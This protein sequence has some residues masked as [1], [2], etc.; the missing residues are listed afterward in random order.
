MNF[1]RSV[2]IASIAVY[3][4]VGFAVFHT[5]QARH[6]EEE[7][8]HAY[9]SLHMAGDP[10]ALY[11]PTLGL[12]KKVEPGVYDFRTKSWNVSSKYP[13]FATLSARPNKIAGT[14]VIYAHNSAGLFKNITT[15]S[16]G[17]GVTIKVSDGRSFSY[18]FSHSELVSPTDISLFSEDS[19][20]R[21][22]LL[23]CEGKNDEFR[24]LVYFTLQDILKS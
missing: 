14:T 7:R 16:A 3:V 5:V 21:L 2:I 17:D 23:T 13:H 10:V 1:S 18:I 6:K 15:L 22:I 4:L 24:R 9:E 8:I 12:Q 20:P 11:I 19:R